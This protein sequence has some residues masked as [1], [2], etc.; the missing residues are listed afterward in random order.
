MWGVLQQ[1]SPPAADSAFIPY[2]LQPSAKKKIK[3]ERSPFFSPVLGK[4]AGQALSRQK[5]PPNQEPISLKNLQASRVAGVNRLHLPHRSASHPVLPCKQ[6]TALLNI[7][8]I[9]SKWCLCL[10]SSGLR[11]YQQARCWSCI[12]SL[13]YFRALESD[14]FM[15]GSSRGFITLSHFIIDSP[16]CYA[17][18]WRE[19]AEVT[20]RASDAD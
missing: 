7:I 17:L 4:N 11:L 20:A 16:K 13:E 19:G 15:S 6:E 3:K 1:P 2:Y 8:S 14:R 10:I 5:L 18:S 12:C 9:E